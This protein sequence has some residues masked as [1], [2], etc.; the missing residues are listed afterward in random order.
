MFIWHMARAMRSYI[1]A[2]RASSKF[3]RASRLRARG[4]NDEAL[5]MA[6]ETLG[7]LSKPHVI[8]TNAAEASVL[9]CATVLVEELASEL[10]QP[11][12]TAR[13][14]TDS[15]KCLRE[16]GENAGMASWIPYLEARSRQRGPSGV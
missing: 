3:G 1:M 7:I 11:G 9:V 4:H 15:L 2:M 6:R 12:A 13:D 14:I 10:Q 8:R 5:T 16:H